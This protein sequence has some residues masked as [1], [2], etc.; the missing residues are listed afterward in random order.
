MS[1]TLLVNCLRSLSSLDQLNLILGS[2]NLLRANESCLLPGRRL[3]R[4]I[5]QLVRQ[6]LR[7][8]SVRAGYTLIGKRLQYFKLHSVSGAIGLLQL[9]AAPIVVLRRQTVLALLLT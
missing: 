4:R 3:Q 1:G 9:L 7:V 8:H 5:L 2:L 6:H